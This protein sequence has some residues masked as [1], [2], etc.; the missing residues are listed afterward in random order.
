MMYNVYTIKDNFALPPE[1]FD[2]DIEEVAETVLQT[3]YEGKVDK[4]IG[5]IV[6]VFD[7]KNI[8]DGIIYP[9]DPTTHHDAEFDVLAFLPHVDEVVCGEVTEL[10]DFGAFVRIGPMDGLIHVSQIANEFLS[11]DRKTQT[12]VSRQKKLFLKKGD[13]VYAKISTVSMK[14]TVKDSK[15]AL[16]MKQDGFGKPEWLKSTAQRQHKHGRG[17]RD[18]DKRR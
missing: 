6:A 14:N 16:T 13:I 4:E 12:F 11:Y 8:S 9:G 1:N 2:K 15:I 7:V 10:V 17:G 3:K 5:I 18:R